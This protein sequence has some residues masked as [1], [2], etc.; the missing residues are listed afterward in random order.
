MLPFLKTISESQS[1][2]IEIE[3]KVQG[4]N[5]MLLRRPDLGTSLKNLEVIYKRYMLSKL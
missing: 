3:A 1:E 2:E 5:L 4:M